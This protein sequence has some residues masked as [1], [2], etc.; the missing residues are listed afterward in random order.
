MKMPTDEL[1]RMLGNFAKKYPENWTRIKDAATARGMS[2][3]EYIL[4]Q[5]NSQLANENQPKPT[6]SNELPIETNE[7]KKEMQELKDQH[8]SELQNIKNQQSIQTEA[9]KRESFQLKEQLLS[10]KS[11]EAIREN[12]KYLCPSCSRKILKIDDSCPFCTAQLSECPL[13]K[14]IITSKT[15]HCQDC[16]I[17]LRECDSVLCKKPLPDD[18]GVCRYCRR[19]Q[20]I[21]ECP[22]CSDLNKASRNRCKKCNADLNEE[23]EDPNEDE[24]EDPY[25]EE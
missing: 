1:T 22:K 21:D 3:K 4:Q 5:A 25:Y 16:D 12:S 23:E 8:S 9:A 2:T 17:D 18:E 19:E 11:T 24:E 10:Q 20:E 14:A 6:N 13:C 15:T 7:M